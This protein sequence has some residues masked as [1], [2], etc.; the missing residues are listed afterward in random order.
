MAGSLVLHEKGWLGHKETVIHSNEGPIWTTRWR[1]TLIAWANDAVRAEAIAVHQICELTSL[2]KGVKIYDTASQTRITYIDRPSDSPRA[3]LFKCT[4]HWQDDSTLLVAWA[5]IIKVARIRTRP[6]TSTLNGTGSRSSSPNPGEPR[7]K[8]LPPLMAEITAVFAIDGMISGIVPHPA[9]PVLN[10][11]ISAPSAFLV[12]AYTPPDT[13]FK[14]EVATDAHVQRRKP[15][16]RPELRIISR[17]GE[18]LSS[19]VLGI[20][21]YQ[22]CGC[23]DYVLAEVPETSA[24]KR[25]YVVMN[26]QSIV[27]VRPRDRKDHVAWLVERRRYEEALEQI[28]QMPDEGLNAAEIGKKYIEHLVGEGRLSLIFLS[29]IM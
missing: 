26:P 5:D 22:T 13:S 18:E 15:A 25:C 21:G 27:L 23:N 4:L 1:G 19:D 28:E 3:D 7:L 16:Q 8:A 10:S 14:D 20:S 12:L 24:E 9:D 6:R 11:S 29:V 2:M 17:S